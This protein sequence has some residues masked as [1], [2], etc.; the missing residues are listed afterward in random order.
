LLGLAASIGEDGDVQSTQPAPAGATR[1]GRSPRDMALSMAVLLVPILV[2]LGLYHFVFDGDSPRAIDPSGSYADAQHSASFT[3]LRP[4]GL[5]SNWVVISSSFQKQ[6]DGSVLRVGY[7]T[8]AKQGLQ[9][10]ESD[11]PVNALLPDEL[12]ASA[13]PGN[14][15]TIGGASW[16]WYPLA[17]AGNQALVLA[18]NGRTTIVIGAAGDADLRTFA[19]SLH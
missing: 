5:P 16:R 19:A 3:A 1:T 6:S 14:Q 4:D 11:R 13:E 8:P 12:G 2:L 9:L 10:V 7:V 17:R 18:E 15:V